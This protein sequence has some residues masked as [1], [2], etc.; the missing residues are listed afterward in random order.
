MVLFSTL[1]KYSRLMVAFARASFIAEL[2]YRANFIIRIITDIFW[3][4]AQIFT[5]ETLFLHTKLIGSWSV[6]QTRVFLGLVFVSDAIY[7]VFFHDNLDRMTERV[8]KGDLDLLL[9]KPVN[10]QFM[11]STQYFAV[12]LLGNLLIAVAWFS[13][14]L[15]QLPNFE[16]LRLLWLLLLIPAGVLSLYSIRFMV[17]ATA[18]IF[19]KADN[20]QYLW[21]QTYKLGLRPDSIYA[22]WL[23][24]FILTV[25]P[26]AA[27]ASV[28]ARALLDPPELVLFAWVTVWSAALLLISNRFWRY[29]LRYYSSASS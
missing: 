24:L 13:W 9:A 22:P 16:A 2:E 3:Y 10:S 12:A 19:T 28:P 14:S 21:Y 26:L 4:L 8:R 17:A 25:L 6:E 11:I 20:I 23:R 15:S 1:K 29:A 27:V 5:F 7:M 18:I